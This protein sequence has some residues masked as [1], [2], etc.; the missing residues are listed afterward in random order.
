M[1]ANR[2]SFCEIQCH[3]ILFYRKLDLPKSAYESAEN[4]DFELAGYAF[5]A[6]PEETRASRIIRVACIQ[7]R[8]IEPTDAPI[9]KQVSIRC[10]E[11][12]YTS[13]H[14]HDLSHKIQV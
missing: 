14:Y 2:A 13:K 3:V 12:M 6:E 11:K 1:N 9:T 8:V 4:Q 7:N 10:Q 5:S